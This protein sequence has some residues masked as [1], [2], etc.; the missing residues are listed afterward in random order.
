MALIA[1]TA[2]ADALSGCWQYTGLIY[3]GQAMP[4]RDPRL[5]LIYSF[6]GHG[7]D[8]LYWTYDDGKTQ[9]ARTGHY[10]WSGSVVSDVVTWVDTEN[11]GDCGAD[12]D[13]QLGHESQTPAS[14]EGDELRLTLPFGEEDLIYV[15]KRLACEAQ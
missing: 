3:H 1:A 4:P 8:H 13:M 7:T 15:L 10:D 6:D 5:K 11:R 12:P 9:C 2:H 14:V